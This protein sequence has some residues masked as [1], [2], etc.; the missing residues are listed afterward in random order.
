M[1]LMFDDGAAAVL[2]HPLADE[3][4]EA[5]RSLEV[6][7]DHLVE[8]LLTDRAQRR[9]QRCHPGVVDQHVDVTERSVRDLDEVV[10]IRPPSDVD[11]HRERPTAGLGLDDRR[12]LL[13][14]IE[15]A[16]GDHDIGARLG[17]PEHH[18]PAQATATAGD[19]RDLAGQIDVHGLVDSPRRRDASASHS[20]GSDR[21]GQEILMMNGAGLRDFSMRHCSPCR[22][23]TLPTS[24]RPAQCRATTAR[25]GRAG[26][27]RRPRS[28][29][30]RS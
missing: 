21:P 19:E 28:S 25:P 18:L 15:L 16:A 7:A 22:F 9:V 8:Q 24:G 5:E 30:C 13:A 11:G 12:Q 17:Q 27:A 4:T 26:S 2:L 23:E 29:R 1:L 14:G 6:D 10:D 20:T 3:R